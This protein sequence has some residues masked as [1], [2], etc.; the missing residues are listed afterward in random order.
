M[1]LF[2]EK[3][4]G[5]HYGEVTAYFMHG[6]LRRITRTESELLEPSARTNPDLELIG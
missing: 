1:E 6:R 5:L 3:A 4:R 2:L